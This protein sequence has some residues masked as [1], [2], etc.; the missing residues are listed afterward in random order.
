M[1]SAAI[2]MMMSLSAFIVVLVHLA[3]SGIARQADEGAAAHIWQMLM[4]GQIPVLLFFA[5][6]WLPKAPRLALVVLALQ[7]AAIGASMAP[8]F[9]LKW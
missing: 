1:P 2:P 6:K 7:A 9:L 4:A 5:I 8:V 3:A